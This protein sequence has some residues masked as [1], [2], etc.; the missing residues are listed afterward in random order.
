MDSQR[1]VRGIQ[2]IRF[3]VLGVLLAQ[4]VSFGAAINPQKV[5]GING[6][7]SQITNSLGSSPLDLPFSENWGISTWAG[8]RLETVC[9]TGI[10]PDIA[11]LDGMTGF[12]GAGQYYKRLSN[13]YVVVIPQVGSGVNLGGSLGNGWTQVYQADTYAISYNTNPDSLQGS[14]K[15]Y[16][17]VST[18][19]ASKLQVAQTT[20]S[21]YNSI[22]SWRCFVKFVS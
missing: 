15:L 19:D 11:V 5:K 13:H 16:M 22:A 18:T 20:G 14:H 2:L 9:D 7:Y 8:R 4:D 1:R 12:T 17:R 21:G 3:G 6:F 10:S